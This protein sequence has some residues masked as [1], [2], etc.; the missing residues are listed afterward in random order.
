MDGMELGEWVRWALTLGLGILAVVFELRTTRI[1]NALTLGGLL[2]AIGAALFFE[3]GGDALLGGGLAFVA[4]FALFRSG[5]LAGGGVKTAILLGTTGGLVVGVVLAIACALF[6]AGLWLGVAL[7]ERGWLKVSLD[8]RRA[9]TP[10][11][12]LLSL[13]GLA[14]HAGLS[15]S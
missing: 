1:P 11:I 6:G 2:P 14:L 15:P 4:G 5:S 10:T 3:R 9:S 13:L 12:L 7:V 8:V